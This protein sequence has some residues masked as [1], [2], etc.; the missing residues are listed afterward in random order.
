MEVILDSIA[1]S[2][3]IA[4]ALAAVQPEEPPTLAELRHGSKYVSLHQDS[5]GSPWNATS[6]A[7]SAT[8]M[9]VLQPEVA[10][11]CEIVLDSALVGLL[12]GTVC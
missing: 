2:T 1:N 3:Q 9:L 6:V 8:D 11:F 10:D 7:T 12:E 5:A 4:S